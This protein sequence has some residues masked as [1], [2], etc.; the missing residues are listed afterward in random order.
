MV[1]YTSGDAGNIAGKLEHIFTALSKKATTLFRVYW[2]NLVSAFMAPM[3]ILKHQDTCF[4]QQPQKDCQSEPV[5]QHMFE[6]N[7]EHFVYQMCDQKR[8]IVAR[9]RTMTPMHP[10]CDVIDHLRRNR[11]TERFVKRFSK[12]FEIQSAS[13]YP[14]EN[15]KRLWQQRPVGDVHSSSPVRKIGWVANIGAE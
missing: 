8:D 2:P 9:R 4:R 1:L 5:C 14:A 15:I 3:Q 13:N 12:M 6:K 11:M 7:P 10:Q